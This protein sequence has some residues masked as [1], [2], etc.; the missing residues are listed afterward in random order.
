MMRPE[1]TWKLPNSEKGAIRIVCCAR[2]SN[3]N[4]CRFRIVNRKFNGIE[5]HVLRQKL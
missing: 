3:T 5:G 2:L 4:I 1:C